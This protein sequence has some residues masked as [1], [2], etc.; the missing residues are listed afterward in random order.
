MRDDWLGR[1]GLNLGVRPDMGSTVGDVTSRGDVEGHLEIVRSGHHY[2]GAD[3]SR[4][5]FVLC[6]NGVVTGYKQLLCHCA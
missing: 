3:K 5:E 1:R 2:V 6:M 4:A